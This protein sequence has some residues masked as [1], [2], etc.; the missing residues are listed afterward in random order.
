[1]KRDVDA[2]TTCPY[3][4][5]VCHLIEITAEFLAKYGKTAAAAGDEEPVYHSCY[6]A[7]RGASKPSH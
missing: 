4:N 6:R 1:M 7:P 5:P 3:H 2:C